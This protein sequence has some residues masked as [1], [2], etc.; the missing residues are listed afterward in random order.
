MLDNKNFGIDNGI[1]S[2]MVASDMQ[3]APKKN[4]NQFRQ[5]FS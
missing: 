5:L 2:C 1:P 3:F 4:K